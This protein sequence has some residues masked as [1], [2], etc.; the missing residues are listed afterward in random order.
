MLGRHPVRVGSV[1]Y[2][3]G[4]SPYG[5][6]MPVD[7]DWY[8]YCTLRPFWGRGIHY[9][10]EDIALAKGRRGRSLT[11]H[12]SAADDRK[13]G[14]REILVEAD[15]VSAR[16]FVGLAGERVPDLHGDG[17][18]VVIDGDLACDGRLYP[19]ESCIWTTAMDTAELRAG[20]D[21]VVAILLTFA[22]SPGAHEE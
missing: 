7:Q 9:V 13:P 11:A 16:E 22:R 12:A 19:F 10:P 18:Y 6:I 5:P 2:A 14:L 15:G 8:T 21:G 17:Y 3:D 4:Y 1:H 20:V